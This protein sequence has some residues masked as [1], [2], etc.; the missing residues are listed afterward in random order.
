MKRSLIRSVSVLIAILALTMATMAAPA[1]AGALGGGAAAVV[2]YLSSQPVGTCAY[3]ADATLGHSWLGINTGVGIRLVGPLNGADGI[4][5][6]LPAG[7][8]G[9]H[10]VFI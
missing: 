5:A 10:Q 8:N 4:A 3:F 7:L 6:V 9:C 2:G 1:S